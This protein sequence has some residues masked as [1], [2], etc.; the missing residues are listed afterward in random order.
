MTD[1]KLFEEMM[2]PLGNP[3]G[4]RSPTFVYGS[5][6]L[7]VLFGSLRMA[8]AQDEILV[9]DVDK[10]Q[11]F[12]YIFDGKSLDKWDG[13]PAF[14]RVEDGTITGQT[15]AENPTKGNTF[16]IW[17]GGEPGDF[18]LRMQ[19]KIVGGN[20]GVQYRSFEVPDNK[21]VVGGYQADIEAGDNYSGANYGERFR[22]MLCPRGEKTVIGED[23]KPK[24]VGKVGDSKELQSHIK[25]ED[26]NDITIIAQGNQL[27]HKI[28]GLVTSEV[29]D[30]DKA[31]R[32][33][34]GVVALQLHAGPPMK[35]QFRNV[36]IKQT[37]DAK[38]GSSAN[39]S[40]TKKIAFI[41]GKP[42]HGFGA[43]EH[44]AGCMLLAKALNE[45]GLPIH[46]E[47]YTGGW[48]QDAS[49][50]DDADTIV[51][52]ADGGEGHPFNAHLAEVDRL[53]KKG[54]GLVCIHYGVEVPKG[55]SGVAFLDWT[56][57][58]FEPHWSVN[59]HWTASYKKFPE[60]PIAR[61][62]KP[63][64][65]NDE[66]YYHMRFRDNMEGVQAILT[67]IPP[68][69]TLSRPDGPH[70]GNPAVRAEKGLPQHMAWAR[71]RPD[72]GRGFG[73]TGGH[74]HWNWGN[75]N[76]RKLVLN[77][78]VWTAKLDVPENGV[79]SKSL[80]VDELLA[81]MDKK[82]VPD[83]FNPS[84]IQKLFDQWN[85]QAAAGK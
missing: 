27:I 22:G 39:P 37:G 15:T 62:V 43:H 31:Q 16:I 4:W 35:V 28:N 64:T 67:D 84:R 52:Y 12:T 11:G 56:G 34:K 85:A 63:F 51:I 17:R 23:H 32:R 33:F 55:P 76:F 83:D 73:F 1:L 71:E 19:Y 59:P 69:S 58:Y 2:M 77:A 74:D 46:A 42:G 75:D 5:L 36:R 60:H 20:S 53:M 30:D 18:E 26:W 40:G 61:G 82:K 14:W 49:V 80:T 29:T 7:V 45:S 68:E 78:L 8:S 79:S 13:N 21:W 47:V 57:G 9:N 65:I 25:K 24:V 38:Q 54:V 3:R 81:N 48:P 41:A 6:A 44:R 66:W 10:N 50:L 70:S 72:G